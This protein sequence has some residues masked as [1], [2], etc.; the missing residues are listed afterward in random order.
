MATAKMAKA[1][2]DAK[3]TSN[4]FVNLSVR[5][6]CALSHQGQEWI[7]LCLPLDVMTQ[8]ETKEKALESLREA[9]ELWFESCIERG[10]LDEALTEAGFLRKNPNE[11]IPSNT[12]NIVEV[13]P[14]CENLDSSSSRDYLEISIPAYIAA[15]HLEPRATC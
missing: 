13:K 11:P 7:A 9:V 8:A 4:S 12:T 6:E 15:K 5:L 3:A 10:V 1:M 14:S 2:T